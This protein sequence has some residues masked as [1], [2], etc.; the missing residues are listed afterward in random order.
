MTDSKL[1]TAFCAAIV[2]RRKTGKTHLLL[3][4][5]RTSTFR[6]WK[7]KLIVILSP[8][9]SLQK[10]VWKMILP[11]GVLISPG[12]DVELVDALMTY[13]IELTDKGRENV[14]IILDDIGM[15]TRLDRESAAILDRLAFTGRHYG[16][17]IIQLS[18]R[19]LQMTPSMRSQLDWFFWGGSTNGKEIATLHQEYGTDKGLAEFRYMV[20]SVFG[21]GGRYMWLYFLNDAGRMVVQNL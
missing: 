11:D 15:D 14:L 1:P 8:T 4:L 10:Q 6:A 7:F 9:I 20:T 2:G 12:L 16:I 18:Q 3:Q 5:L 17:S 19:W 21:T 13:Q